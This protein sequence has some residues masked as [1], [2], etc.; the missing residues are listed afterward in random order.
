MVREDR[1][2]GSGIYCAERINQEPRYTK[3]IPGAH[4]PTDFIYALRCRDIATPSG[5]SVSEL[6]TYEL[7]WLKASI[8]KSIMQPRLRPTSASRNDQ[9][10]L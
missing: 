7:L 6:A 3:Y 1:S 4:F 9:E 2:D 5:F 10:E 8:S